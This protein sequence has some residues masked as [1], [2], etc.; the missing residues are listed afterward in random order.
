MPWSDCSGLHRVNPDF[1]KF[2]Q[3]KTLVY[4]KEL[5]YDAFQISDG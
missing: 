2:N 1:K 3:A 4:A 5:G